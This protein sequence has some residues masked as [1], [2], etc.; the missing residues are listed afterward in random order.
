MKLLAIAPL[1]ALALTGAAC[2]APADMAPDRQPQGTVPPAR[3][4]DIAIAEELEAARRA[5]T[6]EAYDLFIARHE[7]H[8]LVAIA[9]QER[10]RLNAGKTR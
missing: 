3:D 9:R 5:G 6:V 2:P 10:E 7:N 1:L 8:P 4:G